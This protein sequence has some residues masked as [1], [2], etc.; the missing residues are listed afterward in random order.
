MSTPPSPT[1][2]SASKFGPPASSATAANPAAPAR[3]SESVKDTLISIIIAFTLA[4][5]FRGFVIEA[6]VIPTGSMAPT[7]MGAHMRFQAPGSGYS[8]PVGPWDEGRDNLYAAK[9]NDPRGGPVVVHDPLTGEAISGNNV[10]LRSGDRILVLKYLYSVMSP[11]RFDVVV[12]KNPTDPGINYIKRL[13]GLP[14][15]E[16]ALVDG[17][18]FTRSGPSPEASGV[19]LWE[20]AG[21]TIAR[22][23]RAQQLAVWQPVCDSTFTPADDPS[24]AGPWNTDS[25]QWTFG[26]AFKYA[27]SERTELFFDKS[28]RRFSNTKVRLADGRG[29]RWSIDDRY[30]YDETPGGLFHVGS[31]SYP[32][33]DVRMRAGI[34]PAGTAAIK[35]EALI[36]ARGMD[37]QA[38]IEGG[39]VTIRRR[40]RAGDA[41]IL[42][43][44]ETLASGTMP[45]LMA[46]VVRNVEFCHVDQSLEVFVDDRSV[47]RAV[48]DWTPSQRIAAATGRDLD[49]VLGNATSGVINPLANPDLYKARAPE[50]RWAFEGGPVTL[51]RVGL[52]RDL[53]YQP[54]PGQASASLRNPPGLSTA[55]DQRLTLS[56]DQFFCCGDNSPQSLDGRLWGEPEAWVAFEFD[57]APGVVPRD[58]MLGK[59]FFVYWP[60]PHWS[61][62]PVPDFGRMR[63]IR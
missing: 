62:V 18:V 58:L 4:F 15:E 24:F 34:E 63:F 19:N 35:V 2:V 1:P 20:Q 52:D 25:R 40:A 8:W 44:W 3:P 30:A 26:A 9:Q 22:K 60:A 50:I 13:I 46:G 32:V 33:A 23:T 54:V 53:H 47:A 7:L 14:G 43:Q 41:Q 17:D 42:G 38:V 49:D 57:E 11:Q 5:V 36:R 37:F 55:P 31:A 39:T 27:G 29:E 48:Y 10:P 45:A 28:R 61:G 56:E 21:W 51:H 6:F 59:A 12:F 16:I